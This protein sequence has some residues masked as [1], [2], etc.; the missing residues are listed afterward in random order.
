[1]SYATAKGTNEVKFY[2]GGFRR[3]TSPLSWNPDEMS[4]YVIESE[5]RE[6]VRRLNGKT[7]EWCGRKCDSLEMH[8][9]R[10]LKNLTGKAEWEQLML[11]KRRKT[12]ALCPEC[13]AKIHSSLS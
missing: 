6:I 2:H 10:K 11:Y 8:H 7:C 13:H 12:L 3:D 4:R 1:M 9:V 5:H